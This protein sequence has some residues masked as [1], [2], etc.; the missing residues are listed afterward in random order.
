MGS[1]S[2]TLDIA[3]STAV[4]DAFEVKRH[5]FDADGT[6]DL[7][8]YVGG[9]TPG[10]TTADLELQMSLD[11]GTSWSIF[12]T[13]SSHAQEHRAIVFANGKVFHFA[14]VPVM[15]AQYRFRSVANGGT[16]DEAQASAR[17]IEVKVLNN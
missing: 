11:Q 15:P 5:E 8:F 14:D 16:A 6:F 13:G 2:L 7:L 9:D 10:W 1:Q 3:I 17:V 4:T 12:N